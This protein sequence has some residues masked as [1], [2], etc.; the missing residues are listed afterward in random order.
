[1]PSGKLKVTVP[2][3][4]E[5]Q[6]TRSDGLTLPFTDTTERRLALERAEHLAAL[7]SALSA[8]VTTKEVT[9]AILD[10]ARPPFAAWVGVVA[11]L[12]DDGERLRVLDGVGFPDG[13]PEGWS[14]FPVN[15]SVPLADAVRRAELV[16]TLTP[17]EY[18][19]ASYQRVTEALRGP[20]GEYG[21]IIA[22]PLLLSGRVIGSLGLICPPE[23][24]MD[25]DARTFL[26]TVVGQ[27]AISLERARLFDAERQARDDAE[28]SRAI[29]ERALATAREAARQQAIFTSLV[30][31][32]TDFIGVASLDRTLQFVN[33]A[34]CRLVGLGEA[35]DL[36]HLKVEDFFFPEDHG[37][38]TGEFLPRVLR[39]GWGE[40]EVRFRRFDTSE[41]IW[42]RYCV[43][44][45]PDAQTGETSAL[46]TISQ[47]I[48]ERRRAEA[49]L[50]EQGEYLRRLIQSSPDCIKT[51]DLD[52]NL[53]TMNEGGQRMFGVEDFGAICGAGYLTFWRDE[54][55]GVVR[56]ALDA[57]RAGGAGRFQGFC[58]TTKGEPRW[59]D[60]VVVPLLGT[61]GEPEQLLAVSRDITTQHEAER[62]RTFLTEL[63][64]R[65][66]SLADPDVVLYEAARMIGQ[67]TGVDRCTFGEVEGAETEA[68]G[69]ITV[70]RDFVQEGIPSIGGWT[71]PLLSFGRP[72]IEEMKMGAGSGG[73]DGISAIEDVLTDPRVSP[74]QR[75]AFA[76]LGIRSLLG[77]PVF[78]DGRWVSLLVLHHGKPRRW[79]AEE[80]ALLAAVAESTRLAVDNARLLHAMQQEVEERT[81]TEEQLRRST[82]ALQRSEITLRVSEERYRALVDAAS[83][84]VWT[85]SP[86]GRMDGEQPGW[87]AFTGQSFEEYRGFGWSLAV[88]PEDRQPTVDE[89]NRCVRERIPF[90]CE[91]RVK[92]HDGVY[93]TFS[94][95]AVPVF[96]G[97]GTIREWV[98]IHTDVTE[99]RQNEAALREA[100]ERGV[101][102]NRLNTVLRSSFDPDDIE[103]A[104]VTILGE[105]LGVDRCYM[106]AYHVAE[107]YST[108]AAEYRSRPDELPP[109]AGP[110]YTLSDYDAVMRDFRLS[111]EAQVVEDV[112]LAD[113]LDAATVAKMEGLGMR[114]YIRVP[115]YEAGVLVGSTAV[116]MADAP[117]AWKP[118]EVDLVKSA[119]AQVRAVLEAARA[120]KELEQDRAKQRKIA[121]TLQNAMLLAPPEDTFPGLLVGTHYEPAWEEVL[122]GGDF[123]DALQ[124]DQE[125]VA[126]VCGDGT[127]KG[128]EAARYVAETLFVLRAYL[129]ENPDPAVAL[130]RLNNY[131]VDGQRFDKRSENSLAAVVVAVIETR[132][133]R[134]HF[135]AGGAEPPLIVRAASG[136]AEEVLITGVVLGA[137][138]S[139]EYEAITVPLEPGD[140]VV[141]STDGVTEAR[142]SKT[143]QFFGYEGLLQAAAEACGTGTLNDM[144]LGVVES[145]KMFAGGKLGDDACVVAARFLGNV[146]NEEGIDYKFAR[147]G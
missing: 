86:E 119:A 131:M 38:I 46:V 20:S 97:D 96:D 103:S 13:V 43:F 115:L 61:N 21:A 144:A 24:V 73:S 56:E 30:A 2:E 145:A 14:E 79:P 123:Y 75:A 136:T 110:R 45:V 25:E 83:Q 104:A 11:L 102:L 81:R 55:L 37:F 5:N 100:A 130:S 85:N 62:R 66:R 111:P 146:T 31:N 92:R 69:T 114:S 70:H 18:E 78:K 91:H 82:E 98:G 15:A 118:E 47:D 32:S 108:I 126:L 23:R 53:L 106:V 50:R 134:A 93:R 147:L 139:S 141:L 36:S 57:A 138:P 74:E 33:A 29:A 60:V 132:T 44:T 77:A 142:N 107:N 143:R 84:V 49:T 63:T 125:R 109:I 6:P 88:H 137:Y 116:A 12:S 52:G 8:A 113:G 59:W 99:Q 1:M 129:R 42:V 127:G 90:L 34:G 35:D 80:R 122:V 133:G 124:L 51:L 94:I 3:T 54:T 121:D 89:W 41:P 19:A 76:E 7:A 135:A 10:A 4:L 71:R 140:V 48:G 117:R 28:A 128:L 16:V 72:I 65:V 40:V 17:E 120:H 64:E 112:R 101:V 26:L 27:C 22:A 39:E 95:R 87:A 68:G 105:A 67:F 9:T 58:P